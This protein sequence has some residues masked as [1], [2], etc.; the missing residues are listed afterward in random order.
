M[1]LDIAANDFVPR[2]ATLNS[3]PPVPVT[4]HPSAPVL[5]TRAGPAFHPIGHA[6]MQAGLPNPAQQPQRL[7]LACS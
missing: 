2:S 5:V 6:P 3:T 4:A 7:T 1:R